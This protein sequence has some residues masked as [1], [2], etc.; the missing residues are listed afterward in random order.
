[1]SR[2]TSRLDW[3]P[4]NTDPHT[5]R[6]RW[7]GAGWHYTI[8]WGDGTQT[9]V[10]HWQGAQRHT[11]PAP[12]TYTVVCVND[13]RDDWTITT[14]VTVRGWLAPHVTATLDADGRTV[15]L[16][17]PAV[18]SPVLW[19]VA[20][21]DDTT[22]EHGPGDEATHTYPW[23]FGT[24]TITV[25]DTPS[26]RATRFPGP[27]IRDDVESKPISGFLIRY[28]HE[29]AGGDHVLRMVGGGLVPDEQV[30]FYPQRSAASAVTLHADGNGRVGHT[31]TQRRQSFETW[32]Q[33]W[34]SYTVWHQNR[35][36]FLPVNA[37]R[38]RDGHADVVYEIDDTGGNRDVHISVVGCY[39]LGLYDIY[40]GDGTNIRINQKTL[41]FRVSHS[42]TSTP[43][44]Q[45]M[46]GP[47]GGGTLMRELDTPDPCPPCYNPYYPGQ[48][49]I[50]WRGSGNTHCPGPCGR[51]TDDY[52]PVL[53]TNDSG[54]H[55]PHM[56]HKPSVG[57]SWNEG[58][59][60]TGFQPGIYTFRYVAFRQATRN[61]Q[62]TITQGGK[63]RRPPEITDWT[64]HDGA[65]PPPE[66]DL[67]CWFGC[68]KQWDGGYA[69][70]FHITNHADTP[71]TGCTVQFTLD[72]PARLREVW[73]DTATL[74]DMGSNR[75][76]VTST[77]TIPAGGDITIGARIEPPGTPNPW[78]DNITVAATRTE[79]Q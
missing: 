63:R 13:I 58:Y 74:T 59:G 8:H 18:P 67:T 48:C 47:P 12:G 26:R 40:W 75:W 61:H 79:Q 46:V 69:G 30:V 62:V 57:T 71:R 72:D 28:V 53:V 60:Y 49:S 68:D 41:P 55:P 5:V 35:W 78:P 19:R 42:Y 36:T 2:P 23:G 17:P 77:A 56:L 32:E 10:T 39:D 22:T 51:V 1:M 38:L 76:A 29:T 25:W 44:S 43:K 33:A 66:S 37:P 70:T 54:L 16:D 50:V 11:Y 34:R 21:G 45:I 14:Q 6:L 64:E 31:F 3:M 7:V 52:A 27:A 4:D 24:P 20:W 15:T 65:P 73:P 9:R